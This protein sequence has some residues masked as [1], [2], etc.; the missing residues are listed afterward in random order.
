MYSV[1]VIYFIGAFDGNTLH[2][3]KIGFTGR[4]SVTRRLETHQIGN[5]LTLKAIGTFNGDRKEEHAQHKKWAAYR[6]RGE[7]FR[8]DAALVAF[9][10]SCTAPTEDI[11]EIPPR[12]SVRGKRSRVN[13]E[14]VAE[15]PHKR[16]RRTTLQHRPHWTVKSIAH[17]RALWSTES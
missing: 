16:K 4:K 12:P 8:P 14:P 6:L 9:A 3:I 2:A 7:W 1:R 10:T 15:E 13:K 11:V 5:H 17:W